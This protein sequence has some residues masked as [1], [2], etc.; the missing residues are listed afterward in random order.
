MAESKNGQRRAN[1]DGV[2]LYSHIDH[3]PGIEGTRLLDE[4]K[5]VERM[6]AMLLREVKRTIG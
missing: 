1:D 4:V 2:A 6:D 5:R 3:L